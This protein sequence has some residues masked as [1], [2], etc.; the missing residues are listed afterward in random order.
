MMLEALESRQLMTILPVPHAVL[1]PDGVQRITGTERADHIIVSVKNGKLT[2][3]DGPS[4]FAIKTVFNAAD[5]KKINANLLGGN[6]IF[7]AQG[8]FDVPMNIKGNAG[9]DR[10]TGGSAADRIDGGAGGD[11]ISGGAG[12]D[13]ILGGRGHDVLIGG[14]GQ[15]T[16]NSID[17]SFIRSGDSDEIFA[18]DGEKDTI[19]S[20]RAVDKVHSDPIDLVFSGVS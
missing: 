14:K 15:D 16:I 13:F 9:N 10:L 17:G 11:V 2:V 20:E 12:R 8:D 4:F 3:A 6:D 19:F 5:V 18:E 7:T 1:S